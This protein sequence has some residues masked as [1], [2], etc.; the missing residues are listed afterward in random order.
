[1]KKV[2]IWDKNLILKTNIFLYLIYHVQANASLIK[3]LLMHNA[4]TFIL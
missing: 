3:E 1:M 2:N 4:K